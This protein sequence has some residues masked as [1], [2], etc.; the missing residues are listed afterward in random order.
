MTD[1]PPATLDLIAFLPAGGAGG[2]TQEQLERL[3]DRRG[4]AFLALP[5]AKSVQALDSGEWLTECSAALGRGVEQAGAGLAIL[6]G[7]C[8][9][10]L[11]ALH[12]VESAD[13]R[14]EV[15]TR[16]LLIN[17]PCPDQSGVV[18]S[19]AQLSDADIGKVLALDDFPEE[20]LED[21]DILAEI[22]DGLRA[23]ALVADRL[24][25]LLSAVDRLDTLHL[26]CTRGDGFVSPEQCATWR[27]RVA[28]EFHLTIADG[29][30]SV[31]DASIVLIERI[32]ESMRLGMR[33]ERV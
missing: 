23:D 7:H 33:P 4:M 6:V 5:N 30:H 19:M 17:A 24:A 27:H 25:E 20:L 26:L 16:V 3:A 1:P 9:G 29:G 11:S 8:L 14:F 31:D 2:R 18:P 13:R 28:G 22:A 15:P 32:L 12:L 21:E 10:G